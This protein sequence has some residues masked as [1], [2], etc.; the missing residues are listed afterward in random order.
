MKSYLNSY[1]NKMICVLAF[2]VLLI[3]STKHGVTLHT[4][5]F[6]CTSPPDLARVHIAHGN[7][8]CRISQNILRLPCAGVVNPTLTGVVVVVA[9]LCEHTKS[10]WIELVYKRR[11]GPGGRLTVGSSGAG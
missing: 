2:R 1:K 3:A 5:C 4:G 9:L 7:R 6:T 10:H 11:R 8:T